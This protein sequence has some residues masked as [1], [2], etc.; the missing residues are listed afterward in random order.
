[1]NKMIRFA[2]PV[3]LIIAAVLCNS[4]NA[5]PNGAAG[6]NPDMPAVEGAHLSQPTTTSGILADGGFTVSLDGV[7]LT[8]GA[9]STFPLNTDTALT[10]SGSAKTFRGFLM[11]LGETEAQTD[12]AFTVTGTDIKNADVCFDVGGVT[13]TSNDDKTTVTATL[14]LD[15]IAS[16]MPLDVTIVVQNSDGISDYYYSQFLLTAEDA[17]VATSTPVSAT[18]ITAGTVAPIASTTTPTT[19]APSEATAN[20]DAP[21]GTLGPV[22]MVTGAPAYEVPSGSTGAPVTIAPSDGPPA[23][24]APVTLAPSTTVSSV[25]PSSDAPAVTSN[26]TAAPTSKSPTT[27]AATRSAFAAV[28]TSVVVL[29]MMS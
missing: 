11:R 3:I 4:V 26:N 7:P 10:I 21:V 15:A 17:V 24:S 12:G 16:D 13:H 18:P 23:I 19:P 6:C 8:V 22:M 28:A 1:M 14:N 9:T 25:A 29:G 27:S 2:S 5:F 20:T